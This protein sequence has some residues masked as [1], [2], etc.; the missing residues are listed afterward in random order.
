[1]A[2]SWRTK[3]TSGRTAAKGRPSAKGGGGSYRSASSGRYVA[4]TSLKRDPRSTV[5]ESRERT[6]RA[7]GRTEE[8]IRRLRSIKV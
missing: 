1:M 5:T 3:R 8:A 6:Q 7:L 4:K 2:R